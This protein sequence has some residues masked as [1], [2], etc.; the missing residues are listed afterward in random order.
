MDLQVP[1]VGAAQGESVDNVLPEGLPGGADKLETAL[2]GEEVRFEQSFVRRDGVESEIEGYYRPHRGPGGHVLG[3]VVLFTDVTERREIDRKLAR[4]AADLLR[5]NEELEQF[6][7]VASHDLKAPLR[8]I[9]NLVSWI[10]EDLQ[11][12][13]QGE[14]RQNMDLLRKRVKRLESLLDDLLAY[15]RAGREALTPRPSTPRAQVEEIASLV[16]PPDGFRIVADPSL[17]TIVTPRA[18]FNQAMQ[19]LLSNAIKHH[20]DPSHGLVEVEAEPRGA[21]TMFVVR[22][23]GPGIP[24]SSANA[25]SA[26]FRLCGRA[27][28]SKVAAWASPL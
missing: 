13:L 23:N 20:D 8:G 28:T 14:T 24:N 25:Y 16:S 9:E 11:G 15:S 26:C 1:D 17:P 19:N 2:A 3:A 4:H 5:S 18:P 22:D 7:Y 21:M 27:T 12:T 6:A 10:E